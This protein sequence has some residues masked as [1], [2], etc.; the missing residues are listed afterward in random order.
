[1]IVAWIQFVFFCDITQFFENHDG[2]S[3]RIDEKFIQKDSHE[4]VLNE[5]K[6]KRRDKKE[7]KQSK[8]L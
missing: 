2:R 5:F 8:F 4:M 7:Q 3:S 6:N 1:M